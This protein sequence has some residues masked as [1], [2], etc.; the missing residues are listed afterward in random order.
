M[1]IDEP[2]A[3]NRLFGLDLNPLPIVLKIISSDGIPGPEV[4]TLFR[5]KLINLLG[6]Q[7]P[8]TFKIHLFLIRL[9]Q[10]K[11]LG[12]QCSWYH[13]LLLGM[14]KVNNIM[15]LYLA[16]LLKVLISCMQN[17]FPVTFWLV[18]VDDWNTFSSGF[19][20]W[21]AFLH[22][23]LFNAAFLRLDHVVMFV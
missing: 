11:V 22:V 17:K 15:G 7:L 16:L 13:T 1:A 4:I 20:D 19:L 6:Y 8:E 12:R 18:F 21:G 23:A 5:S 2:S 14:F 3:F 10:I 9:L